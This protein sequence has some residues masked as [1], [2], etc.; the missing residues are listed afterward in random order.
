MASSVFSQEEPVK[1]QS[2]FETADV[3]LKEVS[4]LRQL[5]V[6]FPVK[7]GVKS[8]AEI[9]AYV[10]SQIEKQY[11]GERV[12]M[13]ERLLKR[14]GLV[15]QEMDYRKFAT[16]LLSEQVGG[17]YD[18]DSHS[19]FI[20][21]WIPLSSQTPVLTHELVHALQDQHFHISHA[22]LNVS[23]NDDAVLA[24]ASVVEGDATAVM[25]NSMLEPLDGSISDI[26]ELGEALGLLS[27]GAGATFEKFS[28]APEILKATMLFPYIRGLSFVAEIRK[29]GGWPLVNAL[30]KDW[31]TSSEQI[32]HPEKYIAPRDEPTPVTFSLALPG[33][34][35]AYENVLGEMFLQGF[36]KQHL[37]Q[38]ALGAAAGWDGDRL[39][40]FEKG[41][42]ILIASLSVWDT[43]ADAKEF[44]ESL[45]LVTL[46]REP[47]LTASRSLA[48]SFYLFK[49]SPSR[50]LLERKESS[51][52]F[53]ESTAPLNLVQISLSL[54]KTAQNK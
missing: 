52:L 34:K 51:V 10:A 16:E 38:K 47:H 53:L 44:L 49:G 36:F 22:S 25:M 17:F 50:F 45:R 41:Q 21:D 11:S 14:W 13:E 23:G 3:I 20:A 31:P 29:R 54:W 8:R 6:K 2:L 18:P 32:L 4:R 7:K 30:Y 28:Q 26:P 33:W 35:K 43:E 42:E 19:L 24:R 1:P 46:S 9:Q 40:V 27:E 37:P 39:L 12:R 48:D 15:P 5:P